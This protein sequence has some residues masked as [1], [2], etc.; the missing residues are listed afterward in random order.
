MA[1]GFM[2]NS[3]KK[4]LDGFPVATL[5]KLEIQVTAYL[6]KQSLKH[7]KQKKNPESVNLKNLNL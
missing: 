3:P 6:H 1:I 5:E 7:Q 2:L 4:N